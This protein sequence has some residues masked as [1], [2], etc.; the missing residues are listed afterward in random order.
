MAAIARTLSDRLLHFRVEE[1]LYRL[2]R[3]DPLHRSGRSARTLLKDG[4]LRVTLIA[5]GAGQRIPAHRA[6][7]PIT[8]QPVHGSV[9]VEA[10]G[11]GRTVSVG[12]VLALAGGVE[13]AVESARGAAF[14]L[15]VVSVEDSGTGGRHEDP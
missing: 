14:L 1:E 9:F 13:H 2:P 15:T 7:G 4:P 10:D 12:E 5:L 11:V 6:A 3:S 8:L